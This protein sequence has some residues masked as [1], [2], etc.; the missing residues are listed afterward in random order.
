MPDDPKNPNP[1]PGKGVKPAPRIIGPVAPAIYTPGAKT[2]SYRPPADVNEPLVTEGMKARQ[3]QIE[4]KRRA[5]AM[6]RQVEDEEAEERWRRAR[7]WIY[8]IV[9]LLVVGA[10]YW[11][12]QD[13]YQDRWPMLAVWIFLGTCLFA[14]LSWMFWFLDYSD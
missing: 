14:V 5:I 6:L 9:V 8:V 7:R 10:I 3:R 11:K 4:K 1:T 12:M 13:T 2:G